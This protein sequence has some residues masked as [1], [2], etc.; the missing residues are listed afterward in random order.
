ME[1]QYRN[2]L[3]LS[4]CQATMQTITSAMT[5]VTGLAGFALADN[6]A[7]ATVPLT[8]YVLGSAI[9]TIPASLLMKAIGRRAGFQAGTAAGMIAGAVCAAALYVADFGLLCFGMFLLGIYTAFGKYYRFAAADAADVSFRAKAISLTLAGGLLGGVVGPEMA[10]HS[11]S[12]V[13]GYEYLGTYLSLIAVALLAML[14][15]TRLDIP[16]LSEK[17]RADPGRPLAEIMRQPVFIV[18]AMAGMFSYGIMNL[19]MTSTPLAMRAHDHHFNDAAFV[20]QWHMIGMYAPAFFTGSLVQRFGVVRII[21]TGIAINLACMLTALAGTDLINF[22]AAMFLLGVGWNFMYVGGSALLT[23]CHIPAERAKTQAANDFL[24]FLTMAISSA[25][26]GLLLHKSGWHAVNYG[27][28]PFMLLALGA[29]LWL[30]WQRR[31]AGTR[32]VRAASGGASS[33]N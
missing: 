30:M 1:K 11:S 27:S 17:E 6:K 31:E 7:L 32:T 23:E 3:V 12:A 2:V 21:L 16:M 33:D 20:L 9:T 22:W 24:I 18:A 14:L 26:S 4:G 10:K 19:L 13:V 5:V 29:T 8:C 15:L 28:I 25:S